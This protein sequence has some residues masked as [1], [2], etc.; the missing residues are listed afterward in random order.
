VVYEIKVPIYIRLE[1]IENLLYTLN[2]N[3]IFHNPYSTEYIGC[4]YHKIYKCFAN[5]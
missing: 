4:K 5:V 2:L 1:A 3:V